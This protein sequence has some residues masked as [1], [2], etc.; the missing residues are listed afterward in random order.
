MEE[1]EQNDTAQVSPVLITSPINI[2]SDGVEFDEARTS[3]KDFSDFWIA[4]MLQIRNDLNITL[5]DSLK[6]ALKNYLTR[7]N[8]NLSDNTISII[9]DAFDFSSDQL[10][11]GGME[12]CKAI[13]TDIIHILIKTL[14]SNFAV[15]TSVCARALFVSFLKVHSLVSALREPF[16]EAVLHRLKLFS[17]VE[18][19]YSLEIICSIF[20]LKYFEPATEL[21]LQ[22]FHCLS[23][24]AQLSVLS[25]KTYMTVII[26]SFCCSI[27]NTLSSPFIS[28]D[29][30]QFENIW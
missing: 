11:K 23:F 22:I 15:L 25:C 3:E 10:A 5:F 18:P 16:L 2:A 17:S 21:I 9:I 14:R 1:N 4:E 19:T 6:N 13:L 28:L 7:N 30:R 8:N 26:M 20:R 12:I 27:W 29:C 24:K